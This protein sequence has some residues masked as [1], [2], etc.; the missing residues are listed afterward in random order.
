MGKKFRD[1]NW[2]LLNKE[3]P[4]NTSF[5][6]ECKVEKFKDMKSEVMQPKIKNHAV[7]VI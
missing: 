6:V 1:L 4:L 5:T 3:Y 7:Q 2:C